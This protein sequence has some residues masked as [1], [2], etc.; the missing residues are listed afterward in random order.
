MRVRFVEGPSPPTVLM[1]R[2]LLLFVLLG[3]LG[4]APSAALASGADV[5]RDCTDNARIDDQHG[6]QDYAE[7][8]ANLPSDVDEYTDCRQ[9]ISDARRNPPQQSSG[10]GGG[11]NDGAGGGGGGGGGKN[12]GGGTS[13]TAKAKPNRGEVAGARATRAEAPKGPPVVP[14]G[15]RLADERVQRGIPLALLLVIGLLAL[16]TLAAL[17]A[18][19]VR[20]RRRRTIAQADAQPDTKPDRLVHRVFPRRA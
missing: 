8:L 12:D 6:P 15:S 14:S 10:G 13:A 9:I 5:I 17:T 2:T 1:R 16:A 7:A 20:R 19:V 4:L 18:S 3:A 11:G